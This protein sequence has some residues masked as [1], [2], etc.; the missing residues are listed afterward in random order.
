MDPVGLAHACFTKP[1][2]CVP[3]LGQV[4][5]PLLSPSFCDLPGIMV[6]FSHGLPDAFCFLYYDFH[7]TSLWGTAQKYNPQMPQ[8]LFKAIGFR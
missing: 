3:H 4:G 1:L 2:L 5:T 6:T 7:G 8:A